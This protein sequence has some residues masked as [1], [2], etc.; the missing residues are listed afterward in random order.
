MGPSVGIIWA[1]ASK[2]NRIAEVI[3]VPFY[4][5]KCNCIEILSTSP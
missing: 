5:P 3:P 4:I 1:T 2:K